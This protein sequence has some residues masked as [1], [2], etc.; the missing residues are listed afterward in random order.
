MTDQIRSQSAV[1]RRIDIDVL[2]AIAVLAV[3]LF[4]FD[5]PGFA[6]GY[7]G[8]DIFFVISG[9][10]ISLHINRDVAKKRF[11]FL[12][13]YARRF[14]RL[15]PALAT[16]LL[17]TAVAA[18]IILPKSLLSDFNGS[19]IAS[20]AYV[21]NVYFF[22]EANYFDLDNALKPVLHTWSLGVEEQFY[23]LWPLMLVLS[24]GRGQG[25]F[26]SVAGLASLIAAELF[27][28]VSAS[29][30]FY[31]LPFR[32]F[33]FAIGASVLHVTLPRLSSAVRAA[34]LAIALVII[35]GSLMIINESVRTP[36]LVN[37]PLC[38]SV[39]AIIAMHHPVMNQ[40]NIVTASLAHVGVI[41]YSAYLVHWPLVV[42]Y[43][44]YQPGEIAVGLIPVFIV[45]SLV[46]AEGLY[47]FVEKPCLQ[48]SIT[49]RLWLAI[50]SLPAMLI[51]AVISTALSPF[52]YG[53]ANANNASARVILDAIAQRQ[54][55]LP[56]IQADLEKREA[57]S[58]I[59]RTRRIVVLG[60]SHAQDMSLALRKQL[61]DTNVAVTL[62]HSLCDP[63]AGPAI[64][65]SLNDLYAKHPQ[66]QPKKPGYCTAYHDNLVDTL[67]KLNPDMVVF[68]EDWRPDA[69]PNLEE[70]LSLLRR[71]LDAPLV[72]FGKNVIF[73]PDIS[74]VL[75]D[76]E[77]V[78]ALNQRAW[79]LRS[80]WFDT[81]EQK[82]QEAV[83]ASG[84]Q[85]ISKYEIVC[86]RQRCK[87][88]V[89]GKLTYSDASHWSNTGLDFYG[90]RIV[91][92]PVFSR[93]LRPNVPAQM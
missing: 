37:L 14:R 57:Q 1:A 34:I 26:I 47:R 88:V 44:I 89:D 9:Y 6:G 4:H 23:L 64:S 43:K 18:A 60:D 19:L 72:V 27:F 74:V 12:S 48:V 81:N 92:H 82:L 59:Q 62:V 8:V 69:I 79:E 75:R 5:M 50:S 73:L 45:L 3:L 17:I 40:R 76:I 67:V 36:G 16:M 52:I 58:N 71:E 24:W 93:A 42:F 51:A 53:Q 11:S 38:M 33:E 66:S 20:A 39:A 31:L 30:T 29:A 77:T 22:T 84:A 86:P 35:I 54:I 78:D 41:S 91:K 32:I 61:V 49:N 85:Y 56:Q 46:M 15:A 80:R 21:S 25:L 28:H 70:S 13:F 10:L 68:S 83:R 7:L 55:E 65:V 87:I 90:K 63:L 2:R